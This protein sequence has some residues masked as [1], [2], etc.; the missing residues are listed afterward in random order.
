[1]PSSTELEKRQSVIAHC[2]ALNS[3]GLNQGTS[4][5]ISIRHDGGM[6]ISPTSRPY[7]S[8]TP[9]DIVFV[10]SAGQSH[11]KFAPSTEWRFHKDILDQRPEVSAVVHAHPSNCTTL[12]IMHKEIPPIHY[13][14]AVF[15]GSTIRCAAL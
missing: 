14:L 3:S 4:G 10:D 9:E 15:G 11:G 8:L 6:L 5:N 13:M 2:L 1:M 12:A 7:A